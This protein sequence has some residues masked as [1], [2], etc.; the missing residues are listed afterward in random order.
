MKRFDLS[1][2][3]EFKACSE[4][5]IPDDLKVNLLKWNK[6][7]VPGAVHLDLISNGFIPDPYFEMNE[8]EVQWV[9]KV[10]WLYR[11][12]FILDLD[13]S[14]SKFN[15]IKLVFEG[16]DTVGNVKLN[17]QFLGS[18]D[19]MFIQHSFEVKDI[20]KF[21][22][23][24]I[25]VYFKSPTLAGKELESRYGKLPVELA[26]HRVYLRKAQYSF[27]WDWAPVLT[28]SGIWKPVYLEFIELARIKN[29]WFK[30]ISVSDSKALVA[31]EIELEKLTDDDIDLQIEVFFENEKI[32]ERD[33]VQKGRD[34]VRV[35]RFEVI[36]PKLWFPNGY[37]EPS[38]YTARIKLSKDGVILDEVIKKFGIR[39][40]R[41]LQE[42]DDEGESFIF[43]INGEKIFCKGAN[44]IPA[45]CF[46]PR[47]KN[48]DY[49][50]LL[51]MAKESNLNM[52]RVWGGGV[53]ESDYFYDKCDELG[54]MIWQDFM[55]ACASYPEHDDF[56]QNVKNEAIQIVKRLRNHPSIVIWCGNNENEWIWVDKTKKH[57]DEMPGAM[58][59]SGVLKQICQE[60]DGTRPY[61]RSSPW[62]KDYPNSETDGNHH[63]WKVWSHWV[64]YRDYEKVKARFIT[65]FGFQAPP[66]P[67][68]LKEVLKPENRNF[69]SLSIQHHNRQEDGIPRLFKFLSSHHK[70]TSDFEDL[71]YRM[72]LN[73]AEAIKFAVENWRIRKFKTAGALFWQWNDCWN[74]ISWSAIDYRKKPK[75]LYYYARKFFNP[76]IVVV[77]RFDDKIKIFVVNDL[78][79]PVEGNL[80]VNTF[81]TYGVK[82][83]ERKV[84]VIV[85]KNSTAIVLDEE[86]SNLNIAKLGTDYIYV[87]LESNGKVIAENS[88]F[89]VEPKFLELKGLGFTYKISKIGE[90]EYILRMKSKIL[91]KSVFI[92]FEG[93]EAKLSDNFFDLHPDSTI[94]I[95]I[96]SNESLHKLI[97]SIKIKTLT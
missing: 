30:T 72:Q 26:S 22:E 59:F 13:P 93:I 58:I 68:T 69:N 71:I 73:Q 37:G 24:E 89:L 70:V 28:T 32:Y 75:A 83:F 54:I 3:W 92:Y 86:I 33:F 2:E 45:D 43:E 63:Q 10:D 5:F 64:D 23:N 20:L 50:A 31:V 4:N 52:L 44:W 82:K 42:S 9:D 11:K 8:F 35:H 12:K 53:Y 40:V 16:L 48:E 96:N 15:S 41:L 27:G 97:N 94:E 1:G 67:E 49:D 85:E 36:S 39:T 61:W 56:I 77:K 74:V 81:T 66:H 29:I 87:K 21:G 6:G 80:I 46:L 55:F 65:E 76:V 90:A 60:Y 38:L 95:K 91:L 14:K 34:R 19:N 7:I 62:G 79:S 17:G 18:F 78:L 57:P 51:G 84:P 25:E 47:V 88:L